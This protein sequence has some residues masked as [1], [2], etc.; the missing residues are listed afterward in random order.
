MWLALWKGAYGAEPGGRAGERQL[1]KE[2]YRFPEEFRYGAFDKCLKDS[3]DGRHAF[4][5]NALVVG[6]IAGFRD[7]LQL[8][9]QS[10]GRCRVRSAEKNNSS[11][12]PSNVVLRIALGYE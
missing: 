8:P 2:G 3:L 4:H 5:G 7:Q 10:F 12:G 9:T 1:F 11:R 6:E